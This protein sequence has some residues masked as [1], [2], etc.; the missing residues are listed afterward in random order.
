M[1]GYR[2]R[3]HIRYN[4][5]SLILAS[6]NQFVYSTL[7]S[8]SV[9]LSQ[10]DSWGREEESTSCGNGR[11]VSWI[12]IDERRKWTDWYC[13]TCLR[14]WQPVK[15][16]FVSHS[17][18]HTQQSTRSI[19]GTSETTWVMAGI[20]NGR[21]HCTQ[22]M[23]ESSGFIADYW[24]F[25]YNI[26]LQVE[27]CNM[28]HAIIKSTTTIKY[29]KVLAIWS[30]DEC[31]T[32]MVLA[33]L[34]CLYYFSKMTVKSGILIDGDAMNQCCMQVTCVES[35]SSPKSLGSSLKSSRKSLGPSLKSLYQSRK[36][37]RKSLSIISSQSRVSI[38]W[39]IES[40][41]VT[42]LAAGAMMQGPLTACHL[43]IL[44]QATVATW[45][46]LAFKLLLKHYKSQW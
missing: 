17:I 24:S 21:A 16:N 14:W 10:S 31:S 20:S 19:I 25:C 34:W 35:E 36:S 13:L 41:R 42:Q 11:M 45:S 46:K 6:V 28:Q 37:S 40:S 18:H 9:E 38:G 8:K 4:G 43:S 23:Q 29:D 2:I 15:L 5:T 44:N 3:P 27:C 22:L 30:A 7:N 26:Q 1:A 32:Y 33:W 12:E 39:K